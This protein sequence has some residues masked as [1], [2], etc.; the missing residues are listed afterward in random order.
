VFPE[1]DNGEVPH[2]LTVSDAPVDG[3]WSLTVY[4]ED[5]YMQRNEAGAYSVN[6]VTA[7][8]NTDGSVTVNFGGCQDARVN[9]LPIMKGWSYVVRMYQ[10]QADILE[11]RWSFPKAKATK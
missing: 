8:S 3:F 4:N 11:G 5:G 10:P 2:T 1:Q 9:C 7:Q 6:N